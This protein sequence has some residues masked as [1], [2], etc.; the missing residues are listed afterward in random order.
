VFP[1]DAVKMGLG[2]ERKMR[3]ANSDSANGIVIDPEFRTALVTQADIVDGARREVVAAIDILGRLGHE[4]RVRV[5]KLNHLGGKTVDMVD[6]IDHLLA[7]AEKLCDPGGF[8]AFKKIHCPELAK[9]R[10]YELLAVQDGRKTLN[11]IRAATRQRVAKHRS[12]KRVTEKDSVTAL[13]ALSSESPQAEKLKAED[14]VEISAE[15]RK[16][17]YANQDDLTGDKAAADNPVNDD[18][19]ID[20]TGKGGYVEIEASP[21]FASKIKPV[22][23]GKIKHEPAKSSKALAEF[24]ISCRTWLP[25]MTS[26][27]L[28]AAQNILSVVGDLR[29]AVEQEISDAKHAA[30][31]A[32]R[33]KWE[34]KNPDKAKERARKDARNEAMAD[35]YDDAKAEACESGEVWADVRDE[36]IEEWIANNWDEQAESD[37]ESEFQVGW[38]ADHGKLWAPAT[39]NAVPPAQAAA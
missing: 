38:Q 15:K 12:A 22:F 36:W 29:Y 31:E 2:K 11:Q 26:E 4:I 30:A 10:T 1:H 7:D 6:S 33:I 16:A 32:K 24:R 27:D 21:W 20:V 35:D 25:Q 34:A 13:P 23:E 9:S 3:E 14:D 5:N 39:S 19:V 28:E 17:K 37:F 8:A 18:L